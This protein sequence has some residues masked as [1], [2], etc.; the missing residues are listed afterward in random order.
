MEW[1]IACL[2][3]VVIALAAVASSGRL[4]QLGPTPTD[5]P[6]PEWPDHPLQAGDIDGLGFAVVPRG[7]AMDQV[8]EF[9]DRVKARLQELEA[10]AGATGALGT[11]AGESGIMVA[12]LVP[13]EVEVSSSDGCDETADR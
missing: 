4:G 10:Q 1:L 8:D 12:D 13:E 11:D 6:E 2:A 3:V 7:Y 9:C 5:R